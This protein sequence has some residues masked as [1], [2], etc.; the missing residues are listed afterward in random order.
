MLVDQFEVGGVDA[1][2]GGLADEIEAEQNKKFALALFDV[3][4][5]SS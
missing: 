2:G 1:D 4:F 3:A 5:H